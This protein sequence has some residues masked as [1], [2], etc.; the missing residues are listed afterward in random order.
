MQFLVCFRLCSY[1]EIYLLFKSSSFVLCTQMKYPICYAHNW[2][3]VC[4]V[5]VGIDQS[6]AVTINEANCWSFENTTKLSR[7]FFFFYVYYAYQGEEQ[8]MQINLQHG[9][10]FHRWLLHKTFAYKAF[11]VF[12]DPEHLH[13]SRSAV[14]LHHFLRSRI[15]PTLC[16]V[17]SARD[18]RI[19]LSRITVW[20]GLSY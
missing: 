5:A 13:A 7:V 4:I 1:Q 3:A 10:V 2:L 20:W 17:N 16:S 11:L 15:L 19:C 6:I 9:K 12:W 18:S 8:D 14:S